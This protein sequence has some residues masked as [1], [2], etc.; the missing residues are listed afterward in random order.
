MAKQ[1]RR[2]SVVK[3]N[4]SYDV[5]EL[6][7]LLG[8]CRNTIR[9]WHSR[10]LAALDDGRPMLFTGEAVNA[11]LAKR[12]AKRRVKC[13]P[14]TIYCLKCRAARRPAGGVV[15]IASINV[16]SGNLKATCEHCGTTMHRRAAIEGLP[17]IMPGIDVQPT[18]RETS[19]N[20]R[21]LPPVNCDETREAKS[22]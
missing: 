22:A 16:T 21:S 4:R 6:A 7:A 10:G 12:K 14:G 9:S 19:I 1:R 11:Y 18:G 8:V 15:L 5:A 13:P 20:G 2:P 3:G 17:K